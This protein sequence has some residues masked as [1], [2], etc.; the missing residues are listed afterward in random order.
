MKFAFVQIIELF[1]SLDTY[2]ALTTSNI[3]GIEGIGHKYSA[4]YKGMKKKQYNILDPRKMDFDQDYDDFKRHLVELEV[5]LFYRYTRRVW[6]FF[7]CPY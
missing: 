4:L 2:D 6:L 5:K 3:E 1:T 7:I